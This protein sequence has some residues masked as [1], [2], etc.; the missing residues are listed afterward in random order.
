MEPSQSSTA[1]IFSMCRSG[2]LDGVIKC[3]EEEEIDLNIQ[4]E[5]CEI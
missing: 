3:V 1:N 4:D 2:D 5:V